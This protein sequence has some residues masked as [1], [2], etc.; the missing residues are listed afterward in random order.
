M[1]RSG[2]AKATVAI[3]LGILAPAVAAD[4]VL[5]TST[6]TAQDPVTGGVVQVTSTVFALPGKV[7]RFEYEVRNLSYDPRPG[8]TN[9]FSGLTLA[10]GILPGPLADFGF[11]PVGWDVSVGLDEDLNMVA[12]FQLALEGGVGVGIGA[13]AVF[14]FQTTEPGLGRRFSDTVFI[15]TLGNSHHAAGRTGEFVLLDMASGRGPLVPAPAPGGSTVLLG[16]ASIALG[17]RRRR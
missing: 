11:A 6:I 10:W 17:R 15:P 14:G 5:G 3:C 13:T 7:A 9:A 1:D 8:E 16:V 12:D 4:E 2:A